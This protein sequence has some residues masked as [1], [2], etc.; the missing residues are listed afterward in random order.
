M[1]SHKDTENVQKIHR[2]AASIKP[3][4]ERI[5]RCLQHPSQEYLS[6]SSLLASVSLEPAV[7]QNWK[8]RDGVVANRVIPHWGP[9][10]RLSLGLIIRET[11]ST[12]F[13]PS[14]V[15]ACAE[16]I[17]EHLLG[18][19]ATSDLGTA[20]DKLIQELR[21]ILSS[22][23]INEKQAQD[24][25]TMKE[26]LSHLFG[27]SVLLM[28]IIDQAI[29]ELNL[30]REF[31]RPFRYNGHDVRKVLLPLLSLVFTTRSSFLISPD[32]F[33]PRYGVSCILYLPL[34]SHQVIHEQVHHCLCHPNCTP[35]E[36]EDHLNRCYPNYGYHSSSREG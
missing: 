12:F 24:S 21:R 14:L 23:A 3:I 13:R 30:S 34:L 6:P 22:G 4:L 28:G 1:L 15:L 36:M 11:G 29:N 32:I 5:L 26:K 2:A 31:E 9:I 16:L 27:Q 33:I 19:D 17:L 7:L 8:H 10:D 18:T 25:D 35:E 20:Y